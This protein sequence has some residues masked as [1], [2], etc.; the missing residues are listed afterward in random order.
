MGA[1]AYGEQAHHFDHVADNQEPIQA[2][3]TMGISGDLPL[4]VLVCDGVADWTLVSQVLKAHAHYR[5]SGFW[6][7]LVLLCTEP[8]GFEQPIMAHVNT[9]VQHASS[10]EWMNQAGGVHIINCETMNDPRY[11]L[12]RSCA[13][14]MLTTSHGDG[15]AQFLQKEQTVHGKVSYHNRRCRDWAMTLPMSEPLFFENGYG[16]FTKNEGDYVITLPPGQHTPAPWCN[17]LCSDTF[18]TLAGESGLVF[19]Y[20]GNSQRGRIT[21]W[22]N[23]SV[24]PQGDE[25]FFVRD[26]P[27]RLLW[28]LTRLPMGQGMPVRITH[29]MGE[30]KYESSC[31]GIAGKMQCFT[32]QTDDIGLRVITLRNEDEA[33]RRLQLYHTVIFQLGEQPT[34]WQQTQMQ[35]ETQ[36]IYI[37]NPNVDGVFCL[38]GIDPT[39]TQ[40]FTMSAGMF[41]GLWGMPPYALT[42]ENALHT[43]QGNVGILRYDVVLKAGQ[44]IIITTAMGRGISLP[45][46]KRMVENCQKDGATLRLV[47][48]RKAWQSR[49]GVLHYDLPDAAL[50]VMLNRWLPYQVWASRLMM[51]AGFYQAGGAT[52]FR[53]QLQDM[54]SLLHTSPQTVRK[55]LLTCARHQFEE[56]DV[57]HWWHEPAY[58]VRTR[59]SDDLL[60]LPYVTAMYVKA[61]ADS[62]ILSEVVPYLHD[63][64]LA[65][66]EK[67]RLTEAEE[68]EKA[69]A[70]WEHC[71]RAIDHV[72][73]GAHGLPLMGTGDWNDGMNEVGGNNGESVWLGMFLSEVIRLFAPFCFQEEDRERLMNHRQALMQNIE[74]FAWDGAWYARAFAHDGTKLGV[75]QGQE[76]CIDLLPQS[77]SV[78]AGLSKVRS[79][80]AMQEA[81]KQLYDPKAGLMK[82][83]T[84]PFEGKTNPGYIGAY[85]P[86]IR[87]NG[88][89][90]THSLGW[91]IWA[92]HQ[93]GQ[94]KSAWDLALMILPIYHSDSKQRA[95]RYRVEPYVMAGDVYAN[96]RQRGRGGWTW[97]TGSASWY[98][99]VLL[100]ELLGFQ[101]VGNTLTFRPTAP[102]H[103]EEIR[104]T[105]QYGT[106]TYHLHASR[107]CT[108]PNTDGEA[109]PDSKLLLLDDGR[110]HEAKFPL[111]VATSHPE[112]PYR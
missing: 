109:M 106:A 64:P 17:P 9:M 45:K 89:Q 112:N 2:L 34:A 37:R 5:M 78:L 26:E 83:F 71:L 68:S 13:R 80:Q 99:Y 21:R 84:P 81:W 110:I 57:Q 54:L 25:Q 46:V 104:L 50:C 76:C 87:E 16:G 70:L 61:T 86:G 73:L 44:S 8:E 24:Y 96:P 88:G 72:A 19:S 77:F 93:M 85:L 100:G 32:D 98:Q 4:F 75:K 29:G 35:C 10:H 7:D 69:E 92:T 49:L 55:H 101:K 59:I 47:S 79:D 74:R 51:K 30:T 66:N 52:G 107:H 1:L 103:W 95:D 22:G 38:C 39:P 62:Q 91:M 102:T 58:G 56:G 14:L 3:W 18:G 33:E 108:F 41:Q 20:A 28:S 12:L 27:H 82:L 43:T 105:Y 11:H 63:E 40:V 36:G 6:V 42:M 15:E 31:Y 94:Q 97:Y 48:M 65:P 67:E 60:F 90:Y 111:M 23:D 53:D